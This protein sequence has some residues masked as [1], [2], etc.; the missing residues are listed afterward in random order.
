MCNASPCLFRSPL[1]GGSHSKGFGATGIG[2]SKLA[3]RCLLV[4]GV[5]LLTTHCAG[6]G[7][8]SPIADAMQVGRL[9]RA[10][11]LIDRDG[12]VIDAPQADGMTALHWAVYRDDLGATEMLL[13]AGADANVT[14]RYGVPPLSLACQNGNTAIVKRLLEAGADANAE[15]RGGETVLMTAARTGVPEVVQALIDRGAKVD[16]DERNSQTAIMWAA[17]AGCLLYTS[18]SPR[19]S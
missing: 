15:L 10:R 5:L 16:A 2:I 8:S 4:L 7:E 1:P 14:N 19:D 18:P 11:A 12:V 6:A 9:D 3:T 13:E 17:A